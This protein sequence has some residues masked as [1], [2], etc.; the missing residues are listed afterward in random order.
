MNKTVVTGIA[1]AA[2]GA[3]TTYYVVAP[4]RVSRSADAAPTA[5]QSASVA[6]GPASAKAVESASSGPPVSVTSVKA[7][8]RDFEVQLEATGIVTAA[9]SVEVRPLVSSA[10]V[11]VHVSEGHNVK[12]GQLLFTL[13]S[14]T[15]A[16]NVARAQAQLAKDQAALAEAQRQL[17]RSREL[18]AQQFVSQS[19]VDTNLSLSESQAAVVAASKAAVDAAR[20]GLSHA[21]ITAPSAGRAGAVNVY[22]GSSVQANT[23]SL[24]TITQLD[25]IYVSFNLP[26]RHVGAALRSLR[27]GGVRVTASLPESKTV[28]QGQLQF[29]DSTVDPA[30][31]TVKVKA[32]F[33]NQS[34]ALW[35]G[36]FLNVRMTVQ[37]LSDAVVV[38]LASVVQGTRGRNVFV[39]EAGN[40]VAIRPVELLQT[41]GLE[42]VV[43][44]VR[45]GERVIV[46]GR[47]NVRPG[48]KVVERPAD[49]AR[50]AGAASGPAAGAASA[51][52][53][54]ARS[55]VAIGR[56]AASSTP[57]P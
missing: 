13:D 22:P 45:D 57:Q 41:A 20:V 32:R 9:S 53:A 54:I 40:Q 14:R 24:V 43:S 52:E 3:L 38:P 39:I 16:A 10:V 33:D 36:A 29:V 56:V 7:S 51:G 35:P 25:P 50:G 44:G 21:R 26:Q 27:D 17:S 48:G 8:K 30:S 4:Q 49:A 2:L 1:A 42:A 6:S 11:K 15:D 5:S 28:M 18:F 37:T 47:Q 46:D 12:A 34:Q 31:G 19:A 55:S 23:T